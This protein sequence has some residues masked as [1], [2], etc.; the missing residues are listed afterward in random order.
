VFI[1]EKLFGLHLLNKEDD[2][3]CVV[4]DFIPNMNMKNVIYLWN[5]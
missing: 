2:E 3:K 4:E 5:I 1:F